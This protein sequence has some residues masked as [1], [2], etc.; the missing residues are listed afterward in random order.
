MNKLQTFN[1]PDFGEVR[2]LEENGEVLFCA[3][4][5]AEALGYAKSRNAI[6]AHCRYAL[7]RGVPHPQAENNR[8]FFILISLFTFSTYFA[9]RPSGSLFI[10][11]PD[12][13]RSSA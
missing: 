6:T 1:N 3:S 4:D 11:F 8:V 9:T 13:T 2:T 5:V 7:K 12:D 10:Y